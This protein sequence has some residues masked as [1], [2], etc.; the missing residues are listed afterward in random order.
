MCIRDSLDNDYKGQVLKTEDSGYIE[1]CRGNKLIILKSEISFLSVLTNNEKVDNP[2]ELTFNQP[3]CEEVEL[4]ND[5]TVIEESTNVYPNPTQSLVNIDL[6]LDEPVEECNIQ[7]RTLDGNILET[8]IVDMNQT[9]S[10]QID[11]SNRLPGVYYINVE[12]PNT[13]ES[14]K[15]VKL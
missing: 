1:G 4:I 6:L 5:E 2:I 7:L 3:Y 15:I 8:F 14:H 10:L 12:G 13:S 11:L 9:N